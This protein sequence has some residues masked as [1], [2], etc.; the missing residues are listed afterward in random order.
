LSADRSS[1]SKSVLNEL[2]EFCEK[3][4]LGLTVTQVIIESIHPP[5]EIASVY[6]GVVSASI[7]KNTAI[8]KARAAASEQLI[9]AH[10]ESKTTVDNARANQYRRL[11]DAKHEMAVY[12]A[13]ME[14]YALNPE[15]FMLTKYLNTYEKIIGGNKVYVFSPGTEKDMANFVIGKNPALILGQTGGN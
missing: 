9:N 6:Q 3:E 7:D 11:G 14:A 5:V 8:T 10:K 12:Y 13:A 4:K 2:T 1:L 15:S